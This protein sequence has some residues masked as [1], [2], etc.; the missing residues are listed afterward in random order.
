MKNDDNI[1]LLKRVQKVN[2]PEFLFTRIQAKIEDTLPTKMPLSWALGL[3]FSIVFLIGINA[4]SVVNY[5]SGSSASS[6]NEQNDLGEFVGAN[7]S[8]QLYNE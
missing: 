1:E 8:N 6:V 3:G 5:H 7:Q 2:A 4:F